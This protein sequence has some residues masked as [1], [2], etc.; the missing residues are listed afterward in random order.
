MS[1]FYKRPK[2][3]ELD[4]PLGKRVRL[5]R[6][7]YEHG[8]GNGTLLIL[9]LDQGIEHGPMDFFS[10]EDCKFPAYQFELAR[11]GGFSAIAVH[12]GLARNYLREVAGD[13]PLV[14]K[15][16]GKSNIP[17][18]EPFSPLTATVE[19]AVHL[20]ADGIGY[21]LYVG[22][23]MQEEEIRQLMEVRQDC[24]RFGMP[25][26]IWAYP[27][28]EAIE[29]KGGRDSF[30]AVDYGARLAEEFG[31]DIVKLHIPKIN[32]A[33][34]VNSPAP[35]NSMQ[36][37]QLGAF[38]QIVQSAGRAFV[39]VSGGSKLGDDDM[40]AKVRMS[41]EGGATGLIFGRNMWQ[42]PMEQ[43]LEI[44]EKVKEIMREFG[45]S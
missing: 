40:L 28:G 25:L 7:L 45:D 19:D 24:D 33:T 32:P 31:A 23:G 12:I 16:N 30:Y 6:M 10:H 36:I 8:P 43:A 35:Y 18:N 39:L 27:R 15:I 26:I 20:G 5:H 2:L 4:K 13:V 41:F 9:P 21:T 22:S 38:R 42:R 17:D 34:D 3:S 37:D 14:L 11:R 44:T 1:G 29:Q